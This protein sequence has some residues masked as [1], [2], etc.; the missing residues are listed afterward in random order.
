MPVLVDRRAETRNPHLRDVRA[1]ANAYRYARER[2][3]VAILD[4]AAAGE[5]MSAIARA[6]G[7]RRQA[8][9]QIVRS[10]QLPFDT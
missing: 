8:V 10:R 7:I 9:S 6:A 4:A 1:A 2:R 5:S 3:I